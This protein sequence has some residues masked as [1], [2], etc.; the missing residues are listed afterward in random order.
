[1]SLRS[2]KKNSHKIYEALSELAELM[3]THEHTATEIQ[4][5]ITHVKTTLSTLVKEVESKKRALR[6]QEEDDRTQKIRE[7]FAH[8]DPD[9]IVVGNNKFI[10]TGFDPQTNKVSY[11]LRDN[12]YQLASSVIP[13]GPYAILMNGVWEVRGWPWETWPDGEWLI[14]TRRDEKDEFWR[15]EIAYTI[16]GERRAWVHPV[17]RRLEDD[18]EFMKDT[19]ITVTQRALRAKTVEEC[20]EKMLTIE[21]DTVHCDLAAIRLGSARPPAAESSDKRH[22]SSSEVLKE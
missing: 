5:L 12:D 21:G 19:V 1:M 10:V 9:R 18:L 20:V 14:H 22:E 8:S 2:I 3:T 13:E 4:S 11:L 17:S 7:T 15:G 16:E 6:N